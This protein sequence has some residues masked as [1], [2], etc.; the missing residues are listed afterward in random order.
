MLQLKHSESKLLSRQSM[1]VLGTHP[2]LLNANSVSCSLS[3][4]AM[5][6]HNHLIWSTS[7]NYIMH[8]SE[9]PLLAEL[10]IRATI[11]CNRI[12]YTVLISVEFYME[13]RRMEHYRDRQQFLLSWN[14]PQTS[15]KASKA[16]NFFSSLFC[17]E[18][19]VASS[20]FINLY[21]HI[22]CLSSYY[23]IRRALN[24]ASHSLKWNHPVKPLFIF[25]FI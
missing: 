13:I 24:C 9:I 6:C 18:I 14:R 16:C 17:D 1:W 5:R 11:L 23:V 15:A 7:I 19:S 10:R 22:V 4:T 21:S 12:V 3:N 20:W 2:S 8:N 25:R